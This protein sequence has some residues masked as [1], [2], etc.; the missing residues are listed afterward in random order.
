M[1]YAKHVAELKYHLSIS[2][3]LSH[4]LEYLLSLA[5][6][7]VMNL[8]HWLVEHTCWRV[9]IW[10]IMVLVCMEGGIMRDYIFRV[11]LRCWLTIPDFSK[12]IWCHGNT[13][14][15]SQLA[16]S[17][18]R[19]KVQHKSVWWLQMTTLIN[20]HLLVNMHTYPPDGHVFR[21][22]EESLY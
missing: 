1:L 2:V 4:Y 18:I 5:K 16:A 20:V 6:L 9:Q 12:D 22:T 19:H 14:N 10:G 7:S 13:S 17:K 8:D 3:L 15:S 11:E 21:W